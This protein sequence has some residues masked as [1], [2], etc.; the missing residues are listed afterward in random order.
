MWSARASSSS[1]DGIMGSWSSSSVSP[2]RRAWSWT[3]LA[4]SVVSR[5]CGDRI[6]GVLECGQVA[7]SRGAGAGDLLLRPWSAQPGGLQPVRRAGLGAERQH[8]QLLGKS[9]RGARRRVAG[10]VGPG[11]S[12]VTT[13]SRP[14]HPAAVRLGDQ[15]AGL[16]SPVPPNEEFDYVDARTVGDP[17]RAL[18]LP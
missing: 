15:R 7:V 6:E 12:A 11:Q 18:S 14:A 17:R 5:F 16:P 8:R 1:S 2:S 3:V 10:C 13:Q 4:C 9:T